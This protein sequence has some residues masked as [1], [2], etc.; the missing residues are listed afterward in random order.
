MSKVNEEENLITISDEDDI[1]CSNFREF[2][3]AAKNILINRKF[4]NLD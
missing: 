1:K 4:D 2:N 3:I